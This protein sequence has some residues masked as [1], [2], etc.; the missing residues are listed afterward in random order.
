MS[1]SVITV[2]NLSKRYRLGLKEKQAKSFVGQIGDVLIYPWAN[3]KRLR[4]LNRFVVEDESIF[5]YPK[6]YQL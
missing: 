4:E 6:G 1:S 2:Q 5:W 3:L